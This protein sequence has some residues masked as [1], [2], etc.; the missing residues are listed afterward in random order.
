SQSL[1][2]G[3]CFQTQADVHTN[4][5]ARTATP[6]EPNRKQRSRPG[7]RQ[8]NRSGGLA[9]ARAG[10]RHALAFRFLSFDS[11]CFRLVVR[12]N[13]TCQPCVP[14]RGCICFVSLFQF[15]FP[16]PYEVLP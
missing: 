16:T 12:S 14:S 1:W 10:T 4:D 9:G 2:R 11:E 8:H 3:N 6:Q 15:L 13:M 7:R 5:E